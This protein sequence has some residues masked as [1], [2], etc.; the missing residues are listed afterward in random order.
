MSWRLG[1]H[2]LGQHN[3]SADAAKS[4]SAITHMV[5]SPIRMDEV[6]PDIPKRKISINPPMTTR[7]RVVQKSEGPSLW[8]SAEGA[9]FFTT[10]SRIA[11]SILMLLPKKKLTIQWRFMGINASKSVPPA[12]MAWQAA[13]NPS[14]Y[15]FLSI[16]PHISN[17][18]AFSAASICSKILSFVSRRRAAS[19]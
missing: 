10:I 4:N 3:T 8:P 17:F 15:D 19:T 13:R 18:A 6:T 1:V 16:S 7:N 12:H 5:S 14:P 2:R 11:S 9:L